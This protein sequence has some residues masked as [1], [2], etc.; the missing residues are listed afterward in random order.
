MTKSI[1]LKES[2]SPTQ[3]LSILEEV[4]GDIGAD[5]GVDPIMGG[6][7]LNYETEGIM[8]PLSEPEVNSFHDTVLGALNLDLV[9]TQ[10]RELHRKLPENILYDIMK[11]G[12]SDT[13]VRGDIYEWV[14]KNRRIVES[15]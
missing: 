13:E 8:P 11:W 14:K 7:R 3:V 12:L 6:Y 5:Y 4:L 15:V 2:M 1:E 9:D 10:L